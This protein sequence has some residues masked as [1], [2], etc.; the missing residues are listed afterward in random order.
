[1]ISRRLGTQRRNGKPTYFYGTRASI[2]NQNREV[3]DWVCDLYGGQVREN[4]KASRRRPV[5]GW[6]TTHSGTQA[7]LEDVA[8]FLRIKSEQAAIAIRF[9]D[10]LTAHRGGG[11]KVPMEIH[12]ERDKQ[13]RRVKFLND[14]RFELPPLI[15]I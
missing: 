7:F 13:I 14:S 8:P 10:D 9:Q 15:Q 3:L 4:V 12:Q 5:F 11:R 1:M 2:T 6:L